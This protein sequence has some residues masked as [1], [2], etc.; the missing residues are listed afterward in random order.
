MQI[1]VDD[2]S[3]K[4]DPENGAEAKPAVKGGIVKITLKDGR[5]AGIRRMGP[6]DQMRM[7]SII[8]A[9]NS[10]NEIYQS[11]ATPAYST[12]SIDGD[13]VPRATTVLALEAVAERLGDTALLEITLAIAE[14]F[15]NDEVKKLIDDFKKRQEIKN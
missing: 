6:M 3:K 10:R 2:G 14:H 4:P 12:A 13:P 7:L 11:I 15:P 1:T 5:E 8:G 9:E